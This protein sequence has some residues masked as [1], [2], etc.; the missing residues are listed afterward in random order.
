MHPVTEALDFPAFWANCVVQ[1]RIDDLIALYQQGAV[2]MPTFSAH[3][4]KSKEELRA[5][6]K[7]LSSRADLQ[8]VVREK[9][10]DCLQT[11]KQ[12]YVVNGIYDI[13]FNVDDT[14]L[15][16]PSRFTFVIDLGKEDP[17]MHHHSSQIP[18]TLT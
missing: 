10:L 11:G 8:V 4:A 1:G 2:L 16:F 3:A 18:R 6:F 9:T 12:S 5:Y 14:L 13:K 15:T 17:I 7:L